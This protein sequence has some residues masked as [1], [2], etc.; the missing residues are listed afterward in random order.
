MAGFILRT[1]VAA[2]ALWV[3]VSIVPGLDSRHGGALLFAALLLGIVNATVRPVAV[4]LSVPLT[5]LTFGLF[6][7]VVNAAMLGLVAWLVPSFTVS[8]FWAAVFGAIVV[9]LVS[10]ALHGVLGDRQ[11][12]GAGD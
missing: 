11:G 5:I 3:A 12:R 1:L 9:S 4:V 6:L 2:A 10:S 8:G 7:L